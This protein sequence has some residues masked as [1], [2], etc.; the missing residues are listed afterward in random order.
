MGPS[1]LSTD[2]KINKPKDKEN[3]ESYYSGKQKSRPVNKFRRLR[4]QYL[5]MGFTISV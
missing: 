1:G 2:P 5:M 4:G 3:Q